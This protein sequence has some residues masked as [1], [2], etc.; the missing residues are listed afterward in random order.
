MDRA[1][2]TEAGFSLLELMMTTAI[3]G[4]VVAA[5]LGAL[6]S[7]TASTNKTQDRSM[8]LNETRQA[9][10][11]ITRDLRA[12]NPINDIGPALAVS[13]YDTSVS[14]SVYCASAA[15]GTCGSDNLRATTYA[16]TGNALVQTRGGVSRTLL[17]PGG[18]PASPATARQGAIVN[19]ASQP[20]FR[21]YRQN[22]V[23]LDTDDSDGAAA[24]SSSFRDCAQYVEIHLVV[25]AEPG[26]PKS[27]IN[28]VTRADLRNFNEVTACT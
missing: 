10:E 12:A 16:V 24:P 4:V 17:G 6:V 5:I 2:R 14:F 22:G 27:T 11:T 28:L 13:T 3:M 8:I 7:F 25:V 20:A 1:Q 26:K 23:A 19:S 21:Y 18:D 9:L 15:V